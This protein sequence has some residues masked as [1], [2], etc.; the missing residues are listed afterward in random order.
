MAET[1]AHLLDKGE[2]RPDR[3][4]GLGVVKITEAA[5]GMATPLLF[6]AAPIRRLTP[7]GVVVSDSAVIPPGCSSR[8]A[9]AGRE[10]DLPRYF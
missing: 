3:N 9:L 4:S 1:A 6:I 10:S 5:P 7:V 2:E 8:N